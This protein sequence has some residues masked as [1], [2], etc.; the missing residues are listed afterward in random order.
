MSTSS[1]SS[2]ISIDEPL[3]SSDCNHTI[4]DSKTHVLLTALGKEKGKGR[5]NGEEEKGRE[6]RRRRK[7]WKENSLRKIGW[8]DGRTLK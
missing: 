3:S 5:E 2:S 7:R 1:L 6:R 4:T 8:T